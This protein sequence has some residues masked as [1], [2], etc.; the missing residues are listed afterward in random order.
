MAVPGIHGNP[1]SRH[2]ALIRASAIS[3]A[4]VSGT[5]ALATILMGSPLAFGSALAACGIGW[6]VADIAE[7]LEAAV[8]RTPSPPA[9]R[10]M[11]RSSSGVNL[12]MAGR[13]TLPSGSL[14]RWPGR[15]QDYSRCPTAVT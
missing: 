14:T 15:S 9:Y 13:A 10:G 5:V 4:F 8:G 7:H 2:I 3:I 11:G 12:P 1:R 6:I